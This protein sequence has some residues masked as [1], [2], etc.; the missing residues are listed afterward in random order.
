MAGR[1]K[2]QSRARSLSDT[3]SGSGC[4]SLNLLA[5]LEGYRK[6]EFSRSS[7]DQSQLESQVRL[8]DASWF[9]IIIPRVCAWLYSPA[10]M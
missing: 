1:G 2:D 5:M 3:D 4:L 9:S 6:E 7:R 8:Y 10:P